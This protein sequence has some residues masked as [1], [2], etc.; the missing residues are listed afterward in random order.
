MLGVRSHNVF[1][2][3]TSLTKSD[4]R[5]WHQMLRRT[6]TAH[7]NFLANGLYLP[8]GMITTYFIL[9]TAFFISGLMHATGDYM[10]SQNFSETTSI[11]FFLLQA[12]GITFE[13]AVIALAQRL[14]YKESNAFKL[15]G[16]VWVFAWFAFSL[17]MWLDPQMH[18][19]ALDEGIQVGLIRLLKYFYE[20]REFFK[21]AT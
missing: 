13:D 8:K 16:F 17:P 20:R 12:V 5:V 2:F 1:L 6:L 15:F 14:G 4:S 18:A 9:F 10:L 11:Q 3:T 7:G 21:T 19:G